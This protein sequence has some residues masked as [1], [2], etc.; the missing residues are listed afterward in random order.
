MTDESAG[1][2]VVRT[3]GGHWAKGQ[4]GNPAG[5]P[6]GVRDYVKQ[7]QVRLEEAVREHLPPAKVAKI[8]DKLVQQAEEGN[9]KAAK[10]LLDKIVPNATAPAEDADAEGGKTV[11]FRIENATFAARPAVKTITG[12]VV[13]GEIVSEG[14]SVQHP[15]VREEA[16]S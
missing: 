10:L 3:E 6:K 4:S 2:V 5:R 11:I 12:E 7:M 15:G 14:A 16:Q 1:E 8:I 13:D 9:V